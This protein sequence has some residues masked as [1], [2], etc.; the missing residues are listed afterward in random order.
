[1]FL[2]MC[3]PHSYADNRGIQNVVNALTS[4]AAK[5]GERFKPC[6]K[7]LQVSLSPCALLLLLLRRC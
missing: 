5:Y 1:M 7:L 4:L 6:D 2:G 3:F